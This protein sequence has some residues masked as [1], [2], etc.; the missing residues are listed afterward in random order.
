MS[1]KFKNA[2]PNVTRHDRPIRE[3]ISDVFKLYD[4]EVTTLNSALHLANLYLKDVTSETQRNVLKQ[5][6]RN[7]WA[8]VSNQPFPENAFGSAS[9]SGGGKKASPPTT[10]Y[11][12]AKRGDGYNLKTGEF[13]EGHFGESAI[14]NAISKVFKKPKVK[15]KPKVKQKGK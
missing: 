14:D 10:L 5:H 3:K 15:R 11:Q 7:E 9:N 12:R 6:I 1:K 4:N 2:V 13:V 8:N